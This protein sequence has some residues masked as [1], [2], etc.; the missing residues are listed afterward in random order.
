MTRDPHSRNV[1]AKCPP[2]RGLDA[3]AARTRSVPT[4]SPN[5][6]SRPML[7]AQSCHCRANWFLTARSLAFSVAQSA[8]MARRQKTR[9]HSIPIAL[10][11]GG[12][13]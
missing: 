13:L 4:E 11:A 1:K 5:D 12:A 3:C 10:A 9:R 2:D 6:W 7:T 8:P